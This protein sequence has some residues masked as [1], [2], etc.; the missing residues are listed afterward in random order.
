MSVNDYIHYLAAFS[1]HA[2][3]FDENSRLQ[4]YL[5]TDSFI[6]LHNT[7]RYF[8]ASVKNNERNQNIVY[9]LSSSGSSGVSRKISY[10]LRHNQFSDLTTQELSVIFSESVHPFPP[11][12]TVYKHSKHDTEEN[13]EEYNYIYYL[14]PSKLGNAS[15][16]KSSIKVAPA[17]SKRQHNSRRQLR[18]DSSNFEDS[19]NWASTNNPKNRAITSYVRNQGLCGGCWAFVSAGCVEASIAKNIDRSVLL[20]VQELIDCDVEYDKGC[21]GGNPINAFRYIMVRGLTTSD[22]YP[23]STQSQKQGSC[24][25]SSEDPV[26]GSIKGF[27][28]VSPYR[29]VSNRLI[30]NHTLL[31]YP[32]TSIIYNICTS[33]FILMNF[34]L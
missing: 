31:S 19:L 8:N 15:V 26:R 12:H 6:N 17:V 32:Y 30:F 24:R 10:F 28:T 33:Y 1:K 27:M 11:S 20:S 7:Q 16:I 23:L 18:D 13:P 22:R 29:Q 3:R 21:S 4:Q 2:S 34:L 5:Q 14:S 9:S 25:D